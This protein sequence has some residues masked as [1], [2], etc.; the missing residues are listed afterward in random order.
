M[1]LTASALR[2]DIYRLLDRVAEKGQPLTITR[3]GKHLKIAPEAPASKLSQLVR[4]DCI[5]GDPETLVQLDWSSE[6]NHDLP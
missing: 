1:T 5:S 2:K 6:W 4:H 3:K